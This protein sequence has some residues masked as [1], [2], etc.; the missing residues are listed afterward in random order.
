MTTVMV[1]GGPNVKPRFCSPSGYRP[2]DPVAS[3]QS[4]S[5]GSQFGEGAPCPDTGWWLRPQGGGR[6]FLRY[7][8]PDSPRRRGGK[9]NSVHGRP[10]FGPPVFG[11]PAFGPPVFGPKPRCGT[12][13]WREEQQPRLRTSHQVLRG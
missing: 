12:V 6:N 9:R 3:V 1:N 5:W 2:L 13:A 10:V 8:K 7:I 4:P 11:P